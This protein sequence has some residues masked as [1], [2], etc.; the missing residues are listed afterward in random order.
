[1]GPLDTQE[2]YQLSGVEFSVAPHSAAELCPR[3]WPCAT[4]N[5]HTAVYL[6]KSQQHEKRPTTYSCANNRIC[7]IL[8]VGWCRNV[9]IVVDHGGMPLLLMLIRKTVDIICRRL[10]GVGSVGSFAFSSP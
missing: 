2:I 6:N 5:K 8:R 7:C 4:T 9:N 10:L 3:C 1:M